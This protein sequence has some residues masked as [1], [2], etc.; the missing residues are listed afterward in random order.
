MFHS[1]NIFNE[2]DQFEICKTLKKSSKKIE[3][4]QQEVEQSISSDTL[5]TKI[6]YLGVVQVL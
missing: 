4:F 1:L 3:E 2:I 5:M 6:I